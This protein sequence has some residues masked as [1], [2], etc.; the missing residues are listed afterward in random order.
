ML[1]FYLL[2]RV[3][4]LKEIFQEVKATNRKFTSQISD[5]HQQIEDL[6]ACQKPK[7]KKTFHLL[8]FV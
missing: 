6:Q 8:K 2:I 3:G 7:K 1:L 5:L 4:V